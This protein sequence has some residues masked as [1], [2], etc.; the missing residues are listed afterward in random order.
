M[1]KRR[2]ATA[3]AT[4]VEPKCKAANLIRRLAEGSVASGP[5]ASCGTMWHADSRQLYIINSHKYANLAFVEVRRLRPSRRERLP[6]G[7]AASLSE[8]SPRKAPPRD[9][10]N[11]ADDTPAF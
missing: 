11:D 9:T 10:R 6:R 1:W 2:T 4:E 8:L 3:A 7:F 5:V